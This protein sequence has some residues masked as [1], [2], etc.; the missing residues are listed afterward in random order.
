MDGLEK[1]RSKMERLLC[2]L[3][4]GDVLIE[5]LGAL[6]SVPNNVFARANMRRRE[7]SLRT[8]VDSI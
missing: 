4:L 8:M 2:L 3:M 1:R 5:D 7:P 6:L